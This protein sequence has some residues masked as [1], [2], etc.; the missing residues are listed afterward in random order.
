MILIQHNEK[1][2][3]EIVSSMLA[4]AGY[5]FCAVTSLEEMW[6]AL[7]SGDSYELLLCKVRESLE[8]GMLERVVKRFP[9]IPVVVWG[10]Q[11]EELFLEAVSKG[12]AGY[13]RAAFE[14]EQLLAVVRRELSAK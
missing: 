7:G 6:D 4:G 8:S 5:K 13:L 1:G 3:Q 11:P 10:A 14:R 9:N 12:A 2:I